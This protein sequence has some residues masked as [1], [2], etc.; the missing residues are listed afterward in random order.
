M[1]FFHS[2]NRNSI[3]KLVSLT[4]VGCNV[5]VKTLINN[6]FNLYDNVLKIPTILK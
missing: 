4:D 1:N 2:R 6:F 3:T 5:K